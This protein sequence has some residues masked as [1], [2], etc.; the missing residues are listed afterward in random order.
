LSGDEVAERLDL[1]FTGIP[2]FLRGAICANPR[3]LDADYAFIGFPCDEGSGWLPGARLGP[4][5]AREMSLR[6]NSCNTG[7]SPGF[8]DIDTDRRYLEREMADGRIIDCGDVDVVYTNIDATWANATR[9]V[10]TILDRGA[11]PVVIGG[12]HAATY[13]V[14]RSYG[15]DLQF[16]H[17]DAHLD[18]QPF[19]HGV[20]QSHGNPVRMAHGLPECKHIVQVGM[21]SFRT[22]EHHYRDAIDDGNRVLTTKQYLRDGPERVLA[23]L[24]PDLPV[25][26]SV[27]LDVLD[28]AIA[29]GVATPEPDGLDYEH[30]R[31]AL[32]AVAADFDVCGMDIVELNPMVDVA[33]HVTS[34]LCVQL[35]VET[36]GHISARGRRSFQASAG[37]GDAA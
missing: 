18:Y 14:L 12:D 5:R 26:I 33:N 24:D 32:A 3:E 34:F 11:T 21:R 22:D 9:L 19:V 15:M 29:P 36:M 25:Y 6:F 31:D 10:S 27:D 30:L 28:S 4:R 13:P 37:T 8:W 23:E 7:G 17:F 20:T 16:L 1:A 35:L 2:S